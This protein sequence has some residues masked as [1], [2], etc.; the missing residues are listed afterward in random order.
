MPTL[1]VRRGNSLAIELELQIASEAQTLPH[2]S[3]F[4]EWIS[5]TLADH[6]DDME[7]TIRIVDEEEMAS[8]N[9]MFRRK[10]GPTN[11]LSFP[12]EVKPEF[13][14]NALGDVVIC[15]PVVQKES[16]STGIDL[17]AHWAHMVVHGTLHLLGHDHIDPN[18]AK[19]MEDL[20]TKILLQL[21]YSAPYGEIKPHD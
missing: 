8:L 4:K 7:I 14:M 1:V 9:E 13:G 15:A 18:E 21:G 10:K 11:V 6:Y 3:Q 20:E 12:A 19:E 5:K 2:P 16:E 17:L